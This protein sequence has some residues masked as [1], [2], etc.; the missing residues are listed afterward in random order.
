MLR[1]KEIFHFSQKLWRKVCLSFACPPRMGL[2]LIVALPGRCNR[3][4]RR[5]EMNLLLILI[6]KTTVHDKKNL[7]TTLWLGGAKLYEHNEGGNVNTPHSMCVQQQNKILF[8]CATCPNRRVLHNKGTSFHQ[9]NS[10]SVSR[11]LP[12]V[13]KQQ[14]F[15]LSVPIHGLSIEHYSCSKL[16]R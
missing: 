13:S 6:Y 10:S 9:I 5:R 1:V 3:F 7:A 16:A 12:A 4:A 8:P 15:K 2:T 14:L 11:T